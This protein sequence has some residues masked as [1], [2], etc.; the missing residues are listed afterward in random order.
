MHRC[1]RGKFIYGTARTEFHGALVNVDRPEWP[2][3]V[4]IETTRAAYTNGE[5]SP[6]LGTHTLHHT[7]GGF[8]HSNAMLNTWLVGPYHAK[9]SLS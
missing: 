9:L 4:S 6:K 1:E 2:F 3:S 8:A 5:R 7:F